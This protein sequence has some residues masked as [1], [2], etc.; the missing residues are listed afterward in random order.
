MIKNKTTS[1][2]I[3]LALIVLGI[4]IIVLAAAV[5]KWD[6]T[7]L[8]TS[9]YNTKTY[10]ITD[11]FEDISINTDVSNISFELSNDQSCKLVCNEYENEGHIFKSEDNT[12][13]ISQENNKKWYE[14]ISISFHTPKLTVYLPQKEYNSLVVNTGTGNVALTQELSFQSIDIKTSTGNV[15][16]ENVSTQSLRVD[17]ST[18]DIDLKSLNC[19]SLISKGNTGRCLLKNV[20]AQN[21]LSV[22]RTTGDVTFE[23]C[24]SNS[25]TIKASTGTVSGTLCSGKNFTVRSSTGDIDVPPSTSG[26][27]CKI[28]TSTGNIIVSICE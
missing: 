5:N 19:A 28:T 6:M 1:I 8:S 21:E 22:T 12:L 3:A 16:I 15:K 17:V 18:G 13:L 25:I 23:K 20:I 14:Y 24:D 7:K 9:T 10:T 26:G 27:E 4:I 11:S 2:F